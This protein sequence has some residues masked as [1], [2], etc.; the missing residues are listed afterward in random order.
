MTTNLLAIYNVDT[1]I[2]ELKRR[3]NTHDLSPE[4]FDTIYGFMFQLEEM[5]TANEEAVLG[6]DEDGNHGK[7]PF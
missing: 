4:D 3:Y 1:L 6:N 5:A 2:G 7:A